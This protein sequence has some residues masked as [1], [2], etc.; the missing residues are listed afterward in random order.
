[1]NAYNVTQRISP[2]AGETEAQGTLG[3]TSP[4]DI[5]GRTYMRTDLR[6]TTGGAQLV[7][8][9]NNPQKPVCV[10]MTREEA[11]KIVAEGL[12]GRREDLSVWLDSLDPDTLVVLEPFGNDLEQEGRNTEYLLDLVNS[13]KDFPKI[14]NTGTWPVYF[15]KKGGETVTIV[16]APDHFDLIAN[17]LVQT[18]PNE[19]NL[20]PELQKRIEEALLIY[21]GKKEVYPGFTL[22]QADILLRSIKKYNRGSWKPEDVTYDSIVTAERGRLTD[23]VLLYGEL[24]QEGEFDRSGMSVSQSERSRIEEDTQRQNELANGDI[25][26]GE[27]KGFFRQDRFVTGWWN[28]NGRKEAFVSYGPEPRETV[29]T[30][31]YKTYISSK[32][33]PVTEI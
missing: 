31:Y 19:K 28:P 15:G 1:M 5:L 6:N 29:Y 14:R 27:D 20:T 21:T 11:R 9:I 26:R 18:F 8:L 22:D 32:K 17:Q 16:P 13:G 10:A 33:Q 23:Y 4:F 2:P 12:E 25:N 24:P 30:G 7:A 3:V